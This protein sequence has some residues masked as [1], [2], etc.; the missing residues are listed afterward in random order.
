MVKGGREGH[1]PSVLIKGLISGTLFASSSA[2]GRTA[3]AGEAEAGDYLESWS[4]QHLCWAAIRV[5]G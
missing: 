1:T 4:N 2:L 5:F 3:L